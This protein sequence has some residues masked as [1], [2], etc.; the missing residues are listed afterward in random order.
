MNDTIIAN[1]Q[2]RLLFANE[3]P[4]SPTKLTLVRD[5][6]RA[7]NNLML[8]LPPEDRLLLSDGGPEYVP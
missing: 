3:L 6:K 4:Y 1:L 8:E 2:A 5:I 7:I